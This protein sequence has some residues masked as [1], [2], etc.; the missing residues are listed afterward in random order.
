MKNILQILIAVC[1]L[2]FCAGPALAKKKIKKVEVGYSQ[3]EG[4]MDKTI[5][6]A[7]RKACA[8]LAD[9]GKLSPR[10]R[11]TVYFHLGVLQ[12]FTPEG[13]SHNYVGRVAQ[14][15]AWYIKAIGADPTFEWPYLLATEGVESSDNGNAMVYLQQGLEKN[16]NSSFLKAAMAQM[17]MAV[18]QQE[19][20]QELCS[21]IL[22]AKP[23][24]EDSYKPHKRYGIFPVNAGKEPRGH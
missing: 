17:K 20:A 2:S 8:A 4:S 19:L 23:R 24:L 14:E 6:P 11:A 7:N 10:Q 16:P 13:D 18:G 1:A 12:A 5:L 15:R 21:E 3:C 9:K 22:K